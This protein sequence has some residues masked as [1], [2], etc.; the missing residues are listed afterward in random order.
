MVPLA[1][2]AVVVM[3]AV[4]VEGLV[5][6]WRDGG[7]AVWV[8]AVVVVVLGVGVAEPPRVSRKVI[9]VVWDASPIGMMVLLG[10]AMM[11]VVLV[12]PSVAI[13]GALLQ[14]LLDVLGWGVAVGRGSDQGLH[15]VLRG[16]AERLWIDLLV[17][18]AVGHPVQLL[19]MVLLLCG[20]EAGRGGHRATWCADRGGGH[21][22]LG[23]E[24]SALAH[25]SAFQPG[26]TFFLHV[27]LH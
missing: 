18:P 1:R 23:L 15:C 16:Q 14:L 9:R 20:A 22:A 5:G 25:P 12:R 21:R 10:M 6:V 2:V 7:R 26:Q 11:V 8:L 24:P 13:E 27:E 19:Q 3:V 17:I 4:V